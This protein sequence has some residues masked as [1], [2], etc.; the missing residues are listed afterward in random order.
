MARKN[1]AEHHVVA[2][3]GASR[4]VILLDYGTFQ[5][6]AGE[7]A[8]RARVRQ[9]FSV[10]QY[11]SS[12]GSV[13]ADWASRNR[14]FTGKFELGRKQMLQATVVH[15]QHDQIHSFDANL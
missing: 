3:N 6:Q 8:F 2:V 7:H 9:H 15:D 5:G 11:V 4:V 14:S 12:G 13:T 10:Q 1:V